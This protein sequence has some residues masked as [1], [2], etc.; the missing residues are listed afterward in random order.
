MTTLPEAIVT[1]IIDIGC[2]EFGV[3]FWFLKARLSVQIRHVTSHGALTVVV[4]VLSSVAA[5]ACPT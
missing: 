3:R 1:S 5:R 2:A 4:L